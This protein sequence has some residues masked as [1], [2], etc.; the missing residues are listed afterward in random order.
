MSAPPTADNPAQGQHAPDPSVPVPK[1]GSKPQ[2]QT[3]PAQAQVP[4]PAPA[5]AQGG[6][7]SK[8]KKKKN[9]KASVS[10]L[11]AAPPALSTTTTTEQP[12]P[13]AQ[14]QPV[15]DSKSPDVTA[16]TAPATEVTPKSGEK[17]PEPAPE[18]A[19]VPTEPAS[20]PATTKPA[21]SER[22]V[23]KPESQSVSPEEEQP[24]FGDHVEGGLGHQPQL[25]V[26]A[27][28]PPQASSLFVDDAE[29]MA[30]LISDNKQDN[31]F[32]APPPAV[33]T[34]STPPPSIGPG[35][36]A[37]PLVDDDV[38]EA[39]FDSTATL[40][41]TLDAIG[42]K[43]EEQAAAAAST[44][45]GLAADKPAD[46]DIPKATEKEQ[47]DEAKPTPVE[48]VKPKDEAPAKSA[49]ALFADDDGE[50]AFAIQGDEPSSEQPQD[51]HQ[52][53]EVA[54][55]AGKL[56][57]SEPPKKSA[58]AQDAEA[59][60]QGQPRSAASLL[61][62]DGND[63]LFDI[64]ADEAKPAARSAPAPKEEK[65]AA[66]ALFSD[67]SQHDDEFAVGGDQQ[68]ADQVAELKPREA[69]NRRTRRPI[70]LFDT[71]DQVDFDIPGEEDDSPLPASTDKAPASSDASKLFGDEG[72]DAF[73]IG[74]S[75]ST[76]GPSDPRTT[77]DPA[78]S[79][80]GA[81][82]KRD[83]SSLFSEP[84]D[85]FLND[86]S[87]DESFQV[88]GND[89]SSDLMS[90]SAVND[91]EVPQGWYDD[92]GNWNWYTEEERE[93]VR[94]SMIADGSLKVA[95]ENQAR[96]TPAHTEQDPYAPA[97]PSTSA[98]AN[99]YAPAPADP[100]APSQP[101]ANPY[102]PTPATQGYRSTS[103][104]YS[105]YQQPATSAA[106]G[107]Y[108]PATGQVSGYGYSATPAAATASAF[109][110]AMGYAA[111]PYAAQPYAATPT[112]TPYDPYAPAAP[113]VGGYGASV[114]PA[115]PSATLSPPKKPEP[116]KR[117]SKSDAYDPPL[118]PKKSFIGRPGSAVQVAPLG[119]FVPGPDAPPM[120]QAASSAPPPAP[121]SGPPRRAKTTEPP[122]RSSPSVQAAPLPP[123]A[124][125][126][127]YAPSAPPAHSQSFSAA[128][129]QMSTGY[130]TG[131]GAAPA[132]PY[133]PQRVASPPAASAPPQRPATASSQ[134]PPKPTSFD[135][136]LRATSRPSSRHSNR[137]AFSPPPLAAPPVPPIPSEYSAGPRSAFSPTGSSAA[138]PP[139]PPPPADV[140]VPPPRGPSRG[141]TRTPKY[142]RPPPTVSAPPTTNAAQP[143]RPASPRAPPPRTTSPSAPPVRQSS[144]IGGP[145]RMTSPLGAPPRVSSQLRNE[146]VTM[147]SLGSTTEQPTPK[148]SHSPPLHGEEEHGDYDPEGGHWDD[149]EEAER[150]SQPY[151]RRESK[152]AGS[153]DPYQTEAKEP[154]AETGYQP[155]TVDL[156]SE[157]GYEPSP[158]SPPTTSQ[159]PAHSAPPPPASYGRPTPSQE[160]TNPYDS[161]APKAPPKSPKK[162]KSPYAPPPGRSDSYSPYS[163]QPATSGSADPYTPPSHSRQPS[164]AYAPSHSSQKSGSQKGGDSYSPYT[165][166]A[167]SA[168]E[169]NPYAPSTPSQ[170]ESNPYAPGASASNESNPY[171]SSAPSRQATSDYNPYGPSTSPKKSSQSVDHSPYGPS[172]SPKKASQSV[173][174]SPYGPSSS[175]KKQSHSV[176]YNPYGPS[177]SPQKSTHG[178]GGAGLSAPPALNRSASYEPSP[179]EP[180]PYAGQKSADPTFSPMNP[181]DDIRTATPPSNNYFG[182]AGSID[183]TYVPQQVLEQRPVSEDPLGRCSPTARN[184]PI[185]RFGFGGLLVTAFP[186]TG[187]DSVD[188]PSY[189]YASHR[190]LV[191]LRPVPEV[192]E[193]SALTTSTVQFPGPLVHDPSTPKGAAGDKKRREAVMSYLASRADEIERG[194]PYLKT[195]ANKKRRDEEA[196][197]VILRLLTA[198]V[199]GDGRFFGTPKAQEAIREALQSPA[200]D[201]ATP[202]HANG[203]GA[204]HAPGGARAS[205]SQLSQLSAM[206]LA[207]EKREAAQF[208][209]TAGLWSHALLI[210][211]SV[212]PDLWREMVTKFSSAELGNDPHSAGIKATYMVYA[213]LN[214]STVEGLFSAANIT[215]DPST[216]KWREVIAGVLLNGKP[217]DLVC[218]D[219][220]GARFER[221][222]LRSVAQVCFLLSPNSPFSDMSPAATTRH[223]KFVEDARDEDGAIFAEIAE[224]A[225]SLVPV[226]KGA[227]APVVTLPELLPF[228][229]Q[230]AWRAAELGD[231][232]QAKRYCEAIETA[233]KPTAK[234]A[235]T[236]LQPHLRAGMEDLLERLTG[237]PSANP[238]RGLGRS[239]SKGGATIGSWIEGRLTKFI[240]GEDEGQEAPKKATAPTS[241]GSTVPVGPFSHFSAISPNPSAGV[242]RAPS[243]VEG[244]GSFNPMSTGNATSTGTGYEP[245][246]GP[247]SAASGGYAPWDGSSDSHEHSQSA[248]TDAS[249][250]DDGG[251]VSPMAGFTPAPIAPAAP[252]QN[253][254][255]AKKS[256]PAWDDDDEDL[257]FGNSALSRD[258]TPKVADESSAQQDAYA[259][260][261]K[262]EP[263]AAPKEEPKKPEQGKKGWF[264]GWFGGK[265]DGESSGPVRAN[266]GE[267]SKMYYDPELK[268]WLV[269]GAEKPSAA[270][271]APPPPP[272]ASTASPA[273][274]PSSVRPAGSSSMPPTS[275]ASPSGPG[276]HGMPSRPPTGGPGGPPG[277][278][279]PPSA[280]PSSGTPTPGGKPPIASLDDLLNRPPSGRPASGTAK[281]KRAANR[282]VDVFNKE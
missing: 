90:S 184:V 43:H 92:A 282:Y 203:L 39:A 7:S 271:A 167:P 260:P 198:L 210:A 96:K 192:V 259:P 221:A 150:P 112:A 269:K 180:S 200:S 59:E 148:F 100:Y 276:G 116:L 65:P 119:N 253:Y 270:A 61:S 28:M 127:P 226:P 211:S 49:A 44:A 105:S 137:P 56:S 275:T 207:G 13:V 47:K 62:N 179:Y 278:G 130:N 84:D 147:P 86:T 197:L 104:S 94:E 3:A 51:I 155:S 45:T 34:S 250:G 257:G 48:A 26:P 159:E 166:S 243:T 171:A 133:A 41:A 125:V 16:P 75:E 78:R 216:D 164:D 188:A 24:N 142:D 91:A 170:G 194:L 234:G 11:P 238:S 261:K 175:P 158:Y 42:T 186:G 265:K 15:A 183:A 214:P 12:A 262:E 268:R 120:P 140:I 4:P 146:P 255:P 201:I 199:E 76:D 247:A 178:F 172:T 108:T 97:A 30:F 274:R 231:A 83:V 54:D 129:P 106:G 103:G 144:P 21:G 228:K 95:D 5:P 58:S 63:D 110:P 202:A 248:P 267:E 163:A 277:S 213:G 80:P 273:S 1:D 224:Y 177:T 139:P 73:N 229:L 134:H 98:P 143:P 17:A 230:R 93:A 69:E 153:S 152:E 281:K 64:G 189:G 32:E 118:R 23:L 222:G 77:S 117:P 29:D 31:I 256:E 174:Y 190:G 2:P 233:A 196:K 123:S 176:D 264:G 99:P 161:Y 124:P 72:D 131:Y 85:Y 141:A 168:S 232:D 195:S 206:L 239:K 113:A 126:D 193:S 25:G 114:P 87:I 20:A 241:T 258:R 79:Q 246:G 68:D 132:D 52:Q 40:D 217:T 181:Y 82:K 33:P 9:K 50:D 242:S 254:A 205:A 223:I 219:D 38:E 35:V 204:T 135:P 266:L 185:A 251:F 236:T 225:R 279:G 263:K 145:Q 22:N 218:L 249:G 156:G 71:D 14:V 138:L 151:E 149:D 60:P 245:Y 46:S 209:A 121:P 162:A 136:P 102:A 36:P 101:V 280:P 154:K 115:G 66:S 244:E 208:A 107:M 122:P 81:E 37:P 237:T 10:T 157:G 272:R 160:Q 165:P 57:T 235:R 53:T 19:S 111:Q 187:D 252:T 70:S 182:R 74:Q 27:P 169:Y 109:T 67:D 55:D 220:L 173:D 18:A 212:G 215:D 89:P 6:S 8:K 128:V 88:G 240:A 191:T 227:E